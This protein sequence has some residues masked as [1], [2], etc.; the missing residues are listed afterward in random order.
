MLPTCIIK[1]LV[2]AKI[3]HMH[4]VRQCHGSGTLHIYIYIHIY[5]SICPQMHAHSHMERRRD[6]GTEGQRGREAEGRRDWG[7][8][9]Q[10]EIMLGIFY[11]LQHELSVPKEQR[12]QCTRF[13]R[14]AAQDDVDATRTEV[15]W[16]SLPTPLHEEAVRSMLGRGG[17]TSKDL[18]RIRH[19]EGAKFIQN[20]MASA[21]SDDCP[22]CLE[23][24]E[25]RY[26]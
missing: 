4:A 24:R 17:L 3:T 15:L 9:D 2:H 1:E 26:H 25:S 10:N 16:K 12:K 14:L 18:S 23:G 5:I 7:A 20:V 13:L 6:K 22:F 11:L 8:K 21:R 19:C